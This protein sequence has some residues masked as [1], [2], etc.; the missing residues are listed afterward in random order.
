VGLRPIN[1]PVVSFSKKLYP[2][3]LE[4]VVPE[5]DFTI[6]LKEVEGLIED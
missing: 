3:C 6:E 5:P 2:Y 4:L 1:G